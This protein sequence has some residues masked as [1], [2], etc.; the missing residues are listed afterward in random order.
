MT[1]P[2]P[3][4]AHSTRRVWKYQLDLTARAQSLGMPTDAEVVHVQ[5]QNGL[6]TLWVQVNVDEPLV[7]RTFCIF[8]TGEDI[9]PAFTRYIGTVHI[10]W[11]VWH[12]YENV[13]AS[14]ETRT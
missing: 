2:V 12:V 11:T 14:D 10:E 6:P 1:N 13:R 9:A 7:V 3:G 5:E 4:G 8:A